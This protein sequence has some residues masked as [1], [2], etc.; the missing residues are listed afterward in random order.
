MGKLKRLT[1]HIY[2]LPFEKET[3]RPNLY[4]IQGEDFSLAV[5]AGNSGKQTEKFYE[6]LGE[7]GFPL[8]SLTVVSHWHWD[9]TFGLHAVKGLTLSSELTK[10]KLKMVQQWQWTLDAMKERERTGEDI[11]FCTECILKE[12]PDLN[13]IKVTLPKITFSGKMKLDLGGLEVI[14]EQRPSTHS[15]DSVFVYVPS[16]KVLIVEDADCEDFYH[17]NIYRKKLL[18]DMTEYFKSLDYVY[19][20]LGHAD[21]ESKEFALQR[22][23]EVTCV[24]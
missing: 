6:A 11:P 5:D 22:L 10:E 17:N 2:Y 19:H 14:L 21:A 24:E 20:C 3:D 12:Y 15:L 13:E 4:Y 18:T 9:H 7:A 16:E 23:S 8:P 1:D